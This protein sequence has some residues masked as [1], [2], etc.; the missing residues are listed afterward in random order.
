MYQYI[1]E[2]LGIENMHYDSSLVTVICGAAFLVVLLTVY[3]IL[4]LLF[5]FLFGG[6]R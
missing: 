3:D 6:K 2:F 1:I 4:M 5:R